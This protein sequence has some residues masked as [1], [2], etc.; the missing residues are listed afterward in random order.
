MESKE[1]CSILI[2]DDDPT[3]IRV[4]SNILAEFTPLRF[5]TSGKTALQI[6]R[7]ATPD[8]VL[9]DIEMPGLNGFE[10]CKQF[11]ADK[12]LA[13]VPIIFLTSHEG[14]DIQTAGLKLGAVDFITKPPY[15]GLV[16]ARVRAHLR[17]Q[18]LLSD[19]LR[20]AVTMDFV[21]GTANRL[22]FEKT[23]Q[24]EWLRA[25]R[26]AAPLTLLLLAI[27]G[28]D[29]YRAVHSEEISENTLREVGTALRNTVGHRPADLLARYT[30]DTF[31]LLLPET[32]S[33]GA[34][35]V[36]R[37]AIEAVDALRI[38]ERSGATTYLALSAGIGCHKPVRRARVNAS[39]SVA[40]AQPLRADAL[41]RATEQAVATARQTGD[42]VTIDIEHASPAISRDATRA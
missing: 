40:G 3:V 38:A 23:L 42:T 15:A 21:T 24:Q 36:A 35:L 22:H 29:A 13:T 20:N 9:L 25:E 16:V 1:H 7:Q 10:V 11:K 39:S 37:R 5:A 34:A 17:T 41:T 32:D 2:V 26:A 31:A 30:G 6:A 14:A 33:N 19:T 8:L 12:S 18:R 28:F 4:L 27:L